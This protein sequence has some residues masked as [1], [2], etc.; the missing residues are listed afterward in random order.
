MNGW[1]LALLLIAVAA[2]ILWVVV[3][4]LRDALLFLDPEETGKRRLKRKLGDG[5]A[6]DAAAAKFDAQKPRNLSA[7]SLAGLIGMAGTVF[8]VFF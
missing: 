8:L 7:L 3:D 5:P 2:V 1:L 6:Y 4:F